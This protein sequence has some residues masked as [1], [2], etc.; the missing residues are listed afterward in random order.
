MLNSNNTILH[1]QNLFCTSGNNSTTVSAS[2]LNSSFQSGIQVK[3]CHGNNYNICSQLVTVTGALECVPGQSATGCTCGGG[4]Q[5]TGRYGSCLCSNGFRYFNS[6]YTNTCRRMCTIGEGYSSANPCSCGP[7]GTFGGSGGSCSCTNGRT[8]DPFNGCERV[9]SPGEVSQGS[10]ACICAG[11]ATYD[12][13]NKCTCPAGQTYSATGCGA[14]ETITLNSVSI[15]G[16]TV[17]IDFSAS[18]LGGANCAVLKDTADTNMHH[19]LALC[20]NNGPISYDRATY[21]TSS[22]QSGIQVKLCNT[23]TGTCSTLV[24]VTGN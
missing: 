15:S 16:S 20:F 4:A 5:P 13:Q 17:T 9:C 1:T 11:S 22:F 8:Y 2:Q 21:F 10:D 6:N 23:T 12:S 7:Y 24:T 18:S 19:S 3:L 14:S